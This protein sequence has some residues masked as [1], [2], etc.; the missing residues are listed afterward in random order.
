MLK[1]PH[2]ESALCEEQY[3]EDLPADVDDLILANECPACGKFIVFSLD[4]ETYTVWNLSVQKGM[5]PADQKYKKWLE[6]G[7]P[8]I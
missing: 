4:E 8:Q 5:S 2:C 3:E 6:S 7:R 1:C